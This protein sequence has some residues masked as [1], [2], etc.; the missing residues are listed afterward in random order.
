M[1]YSMMSRVWGVDAPLY[2]EGEGLEVEK[3][4]GIVVITGRV[5]LRLFPGSL[6]VPGW[7]M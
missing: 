7:R 4:W 1:Y 2:E 5:A 3:S 6:G